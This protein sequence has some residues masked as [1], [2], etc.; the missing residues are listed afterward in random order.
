MFRTLFFFR[1]RTELFFRT[2][3]EPEPN[4]NPTF[5]PELRTEPELFRK[6][7]KINFKIVPN[8]LRLTN[9]YI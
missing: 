4:P 5:L 6:T 8:R 3:N 1:T 7:P 9:K 2:Q